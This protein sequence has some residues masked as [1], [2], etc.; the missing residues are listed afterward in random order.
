MNLKDLIYKNR[1]YRRFDESH[2]IEMSTLESFIDLARMS[3]SGANRQPLKFLLFNK[4][5]KSF[6]FRFIVTSAVNYCAN[7]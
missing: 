3:A 6:E 2:R 7:A 1:T 5:S 4:I